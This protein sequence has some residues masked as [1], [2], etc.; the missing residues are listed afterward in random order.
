MGANAGQVFYLTQPGIHEG[1]DGTEMTPTM[2][3]WRVLGY[4]QYLETSLAAR[5]I[6]FGLL[7]VVSLALAVA[8][9]RSRARQACCRWR[10]PDHLAGSFFVLP[11]ADARYNFWA[12]LVFIVTF[13]SVLPASRSRFRPPG[14]ELHSDTR[15]T[16]PREKR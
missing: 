16:L 7:A 3:T 13:C 8:T 4:L 11:A 14:S 15:R 2:L 6:F 1:E 10:A 12:N 9:D 5:S